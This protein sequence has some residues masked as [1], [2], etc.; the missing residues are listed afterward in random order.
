MN[1]VML[2]R[3]VHLL[4]V[5]LW[6]GGIVAVAFAAGSAVDSAKQETAAALRAAALKVATPGMLL[7]WIGGLAMLVPHFMSL[8]V[9]AGWMHGKL[10]LVVIASGLSGAIAGQLRKAASGAAPL[11]AGKVR[12]LGTAMIVIAVLVVFLATVRPGS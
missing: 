2:M 5:I 10:A 6:I 3:F 11:D 1:A 7:A 8:Y 12:A 9:R 4:G